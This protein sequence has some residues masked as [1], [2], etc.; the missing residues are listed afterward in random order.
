MRTKASDVRFVD[1]WQVEVDLLDKTTRTMVWQSLLKSDAE[2]SKIG[3]C[4]KS[5]IRFQQSTTDRKVR[6]E[7]PLGSPV[8]LVCLEEQMQSHSESTDKY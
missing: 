4:I 7:R 5:K 1:D 8:L 6:P 2:A 3:C